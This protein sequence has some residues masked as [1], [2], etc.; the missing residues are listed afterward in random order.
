MAM[1]DTEWVRIIHRQSATLK[2]FLVRLR[3]GADWIIYGNDLIQVGLRFVPRKSCRYILLG[4]HGRGEAGGMAGLQRGG[5]P[6]LLGNP[7]EN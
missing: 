5:P 6:T 3:D 4:R 2:S 1:P 7:Q